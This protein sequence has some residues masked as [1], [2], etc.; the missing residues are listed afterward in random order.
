MTFGAICALALWGATLGA[1]PG[2]VVGYGVASLSDAAMSARLAA[3]FKAHGQP[4]FLMGDPS[5]GLQQGDLLK[6]PDRAIL[7]DGN[8]WQTLQTEGALDALR[9][10]QGK[11][12]QLRARAKES[13]WEERRRLVNGPLDKKTYAFGA[14][15]LRSLEGLAGKPLDGRMQLSFE[16]GDLVILAPRSFLDA[17]RIQP[18]ADAGSRGEHVSAHPLFVSPPPPAR[19]FAERPFFWRAWAIDS[20]GGP[21]GDIRV[22]LLSR[23]PAGLRWDPA[24]HILFG[25]WSE[26]RWPFLV[27]ARAPNGRSDTLRATLEAR[28][29]RPPR[30]T[31][32]VPP[33]W[34]GESWVFQPSPSDSDHPTDSLAIAA[35]T[36]PPG[37]LWDARSG[38]IR[39]TPPDSLAGRAATL[40]LVVSDPLGDSTEFVKIVEVAR[41]EQRVS[42][43]GLAI[44]PPWDTLVA[45]RSY[46]WS[47][48]TSREAWR[49]QGTLLDSVSGSSATSWDG[50]TLEIVPDE[51][52]THET[53]FHFRVDGVP[54]KKTFVFPVRAD[55]PP[56]WLSRTSGQSIVVGD[57]VRYHPVAIDPEGDTVRIE[58]VGVLPSGTHWNGDALEVAPGSAGWSTIALRATDAHGQWSE[59]V[60]AWNA[61]SSVRRAWSVRHERHALA[62]PTEAMF[63]SGSGRIGFFAVDLERTF[64]WYPDWVKQDWPMVFAGA[65]LL[66]S[67]RNQLWLDIGLVI[68][69]PA[70]RLITGGGMLRL[71]GRFHPSSTIPLQV[72][73]SALGWVHQGILAV[74]TAG[75]RLTISPED[76]LGSVL[77]IR[78]TWEPSI[79][80]VLSDAYA[81][82]NAVLLTRLEAWYAIHPHL[83]IAPV[84]WRE[85]RLTHA[86]DRQYLGVGARSEF[87]L[88]PVAIRPALRGGWGAENSGWGVWGDVALGTPSTRSAR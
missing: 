5:V 1:S 29:N 19:L 31:G 50:S 55:H 18:G 44:R 76:S 71:E 69:R 16:N 21:S 7:I 23:I 61:R 46:A 10:S 41:R 22:D 6:F 17:L 74:D 83:Q 26:G 38:R 79:R 28:R 73:A 53:V 59:Q 57:T 37:A 85:D 54:V 14:S 87:V 33:A 34:A 13:I 80:Q 60:V 78:D 43:D 67:E 24:S 45:H 49:S 70:S 20:S 56:V 58:P 11:V 9:R 39:W 64:L 86:A 32:S 35:R 40:R 52:G 8:V 42:T 84:F 27:V 62:A 3:R 65:N 81:D 30:L 51:P 77:D 4:V 82:H 75:L 36:I 25:T 88:G 66:G 47:T 2:P 12:V 72:E 15:I 63:V 68:R 48:A